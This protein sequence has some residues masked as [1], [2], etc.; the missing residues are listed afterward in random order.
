M[1]RLVT[2]SRV[3]A[4][5]AMPWTST[6]AST[7]ALAMTRAYRSDRYGVNDNR[8][9]APASG[10]PYSVPVRWLGLACVLLAG[11]ATAAQ[12]ISVDKLLG[13]GRLVA[14]APAVRAGGR[15]SAQALRLDAQALSAAG[16]TAV[17]TYGASRPLAPICRFFKRRGFRTVLVGIADPTDPGE[18][19]RAA[20]LKRCADGYVVGTGGLTARRYDRAALDRAIR[21]VRGAT[22]RPVTTREPLAAYRDDPSLLRAG[23]WVFPIIHPWEAEQRDSQA[24]CGWTIFAYRELAERAPAGIATLIAETGLPTA[25][26][27]ATSEHYQ[28]AF[29]MCLESRQV[30][31]GYFVAFDRPSAADDGV[32]A[33]FGLFDADGV[34]KLWAAQQMRPTLAAERTGGRLHGR[35]AGA[36][37]R[38]LRVVVYVGGARWESGPIVDP[39]RRGHWQATVPADRPVAVY[40]AWASWTPPAA[41]DQ[42]PRVDRSMVLAKQDLPAM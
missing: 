13:S 11:G 9:V 35:I 6:I 22:G 21:S 33:H 31:F 10:P 38:G 15:A 34:P 3:E 4:A 5:V 25:G 8:P 42:P 20:R 40:L 32:A 23:D 1:G 26:A 17:T 37:P 16:F 39:D 27:L 29:F 7:I 30:P 12:A 41:V 2:W 24:A 28:R 18:R 19:R 36:P 14:Y